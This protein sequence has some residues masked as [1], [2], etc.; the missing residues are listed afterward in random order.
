M[1]VT[2]PFADHAARM[3]DTLSNGERALIASI[4]CEPP[5]TRRLME[6]GLTPGTEVLVV[7]R[8]PLGD[9]IEIAVRG[10]HLWLRRSEASRIDVSPV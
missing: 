4:D 7:R 9:P 1:S 8:A 5:V 2:A 10:V 3:L 6:L